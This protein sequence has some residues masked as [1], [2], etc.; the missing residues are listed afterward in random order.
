MREVVGLVALGRDDENTVRLRV[1][2]RALLGLP[3]RPLLG[4]VAAVEEPRVGEV[5]VVRH[6]DAVAR[7][8][9]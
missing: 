2:D 7:R 9:T 5:A 3:D 8:P 4:V 1:L 6:V